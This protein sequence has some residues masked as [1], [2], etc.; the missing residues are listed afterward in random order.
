MGQERVG[1]PLKHRVGEL[2]RTTHALHQRGQN[3]FV[4]HAAQPLDSRRITH[5][6]QHGLE[7]PGPEPGRHRG[8]QPVQQP[9]LPQV[10][11][12]H[13]VHP[14]DRRMLKQRLRSIGRSGDRPEH[15]GLG[16]D[17]QRVAGGQRMIGGPGGDNAVHQV[18]E[19]GALFTHPA[20]ERRGQPPRP[21]EIEHNL[22]QL[23]GVVF[24][25]FAR[26]HHHRGEPRLVAGPQH[27]Q[28]LRRHRGGGLRFQPVGR[29]QSVARLGRI[30]DNPAQRR[31]TGHI[32]H[33]P[34]LRGRRESPGNRRHRLDT[35]DGRSLR[36][37]PDRNVE[38]LGLRVQQFGAGTGSRLNHHDPPDPLPRQVGLVHKAVDKRA[39][40]PPGPKL[41][42]RFGQQGP[43]IRHRG[44]SRADRRR[45]VT[46]RAHAPTATT[47]LMTP[48]SGRVYEGKTSISSSNWAR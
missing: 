46:S 14:L 41:E 5:H 43:G 6:L 44:V 48:V 7:A 31:G 13:V 11:G 33:S 10:P 1:K 29:V 30:G 42:Q 3:L 9:H 23:G 37:P 25:Q 27:L 32:E 21:G 22:P 36:Q 20:Q 18:F 17:Q 12:S 39:Q 34:P 26:E 2:D 8:V 16:R 28:Q 38:S 35:I 19:P 24:D 47:A 40:K 4:G 45:D 15:V